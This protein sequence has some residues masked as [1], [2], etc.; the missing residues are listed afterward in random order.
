MYATDIGANTVRRINLTTGGVQTIADGFA[1]PWGLWGE[2]KTLYVASSSSGRIQQVDLATGGSSD[3]A[4][5]GSGTPRNCSLGSGCLGYFVPGP[6][7]MWADGKSLYISGYSGTV[8][9]VDLA[10]GTQ[11][12]LP[13]VPFNVG[14][15]V[16]KA[17]RLFVAGIAGAQLGS[18]SLDTGAF[19]PIPLPPD[20]LSISALWSDATTFISHKVSIRAGKRFDVS[21]CRQAK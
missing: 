9:R 7:S 10:T 20:N 2:G 13:A 1:F 12:P 14:P 16:G 3:V 17:G 15:I 11:T 6:R 21:I 19:T 8:K 5:T 4:V 18:L